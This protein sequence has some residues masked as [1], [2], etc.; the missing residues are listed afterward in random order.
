MVGVTFPYTT[1]STNISSTNS[2][3]RKYSSIR[4]TYVYTTHKRPHKPCLLPHATPAITYTT[5]T[6]VLTEMPALIKERATML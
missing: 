5:P 2:L 6:T 3:E 4:N 1:Q